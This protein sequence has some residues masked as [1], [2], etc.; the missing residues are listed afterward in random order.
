M[1]TDNQCMMVGKKIIQMYKMKKLSQNDFYVRIEKDESMILISSVNQDDNSHLNKNVKV[2][3]INNDHIRH[4]LN[5]NF[6][7]PN[8][9]HWAMPFGDYSNQIHDIILQFYNE[10]DVFLFEMELPKN[11]YHTYQKIDG[12][13]DFQSVYSEMVKNGKDGDHFVE[14]G[15]W[16]GRSATFMA[17]EIKQS[18]KNI[19][20]D[21][22][23]TWEGSNEFYHNEFKKKYNVFEEFLKNTEP[24]KEYINPRKECSYIA[25]KYY[26]D[27]SLDFVFI[28]ADHSYDIV[29][30]DISNWYP[31]VKIGGVIAGHDYYNS[32]QVINAVK[33]TIGDDITTNRL[34]W[35]HVKKTKELPNENKNI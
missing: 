10:N 28:D 16:L 30:K 34:S 27:E 22:I 18:G 12:W 3:F 20:F 13:F 17:T 26:D 6:A 24:L 33:D 11:E 29:I 35:I 31:K 14:I 23:D 5:A 9:L 8:Q 4:V 15:S 7:I 19:K 2:K 25:P 21:V 32:N 1:I